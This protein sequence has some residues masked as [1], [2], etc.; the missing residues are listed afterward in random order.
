M[1]IYGL[2]LQ[3]APASEPITLDEAKV[4]IGIANGITYHD[5]Y[6]EN[7]ITAARQKVEIDTGR[8][9]I[10]QTWDFVFDC[11]PLGLDAIYLPKAPLSSVTHVKYYD[12]SNVQQTMATTVYK[13]LTT[14]EPGEIRLKYQQAWPF[15][16]SEA[17]VIE[18]RFVAGYG[19]TATSVPAG[20]R[21]AMLM[22]MGHWF[23][24][25]EA[26]ITGTIQAANE[27]AYE[28]LISQF[29]VG[30]EFHAYAR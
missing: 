5:R 8:A 4:Q 19:T 30:D 23:N 20:L 1:A 21:Q 29:L 27:F 9:M 16:Y 10:N 26:T 17:G 11:F 22:L 24:N 6:I 12:T 28:A 15:L 18:V 2:T 14:R 3:T 25:R 7:L 13:T